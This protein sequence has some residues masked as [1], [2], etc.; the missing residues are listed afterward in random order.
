MWKNHLSKAE[1]VESLN[2]TLNGYPGVQL[3]F[4]QPISSSLM[5]C[6]PELKHNW[7]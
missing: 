4:S 3:N 7:Q 5:S 6:F 1:L 2:N